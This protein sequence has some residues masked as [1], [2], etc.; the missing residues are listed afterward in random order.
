MDKDDGMLKDNWRIYKWIFLLGS[1]V[2]A[3]YIVSK[4]AS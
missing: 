3:A 1:V 4:Y 2:L